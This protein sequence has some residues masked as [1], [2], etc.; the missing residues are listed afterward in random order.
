MKKILVVC[1]LLVISACSTVIPAPDKASSLVYLSANNKNTLLAQRIDGKTVSD[2]RYFRLEP[3]AHE[4][5]VLIVSQSF[6]GGT[7]SRFANVEFDNFQA[8]NSYRLSLIGGS[9]NL[10]LQLHDEKGALVKEISI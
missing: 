6:E 7:V 9:H 1:M 10:H 2:G 5:E 4:L 8:D 3:G